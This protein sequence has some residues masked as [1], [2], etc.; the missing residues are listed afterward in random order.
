MKWIKQGNRLWISET[1]MIITDES[2]ICG[3]RKMKFYFLYK[4]Q[5]QRYL[6]NNMASAKSLKEIKAKAVIC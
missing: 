5:E 4:N 3:G 6:G 2:F 1:G